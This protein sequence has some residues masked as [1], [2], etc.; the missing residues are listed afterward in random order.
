MAIWQFDFNIIP[1]VHDTT[2]I[3]S[4]IGVKLDGEAIQ[5]LQNILG[6]QTSWSVDIMQFGK[7]DET[8]I[9]ILKEKD[10]IDEIACRLDLR[11]LRREELKKILTYINQLNAELYYL[12]KV[13]PVSLPVCLSLIKKSDAIRY[14]QNPAKFLEEL[15]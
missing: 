15:S 12:G 5:D 11:T 10:E 8:C 2:N 1:K 6:S 14:C 4:W 3:L 7:D 9:K 13:Y